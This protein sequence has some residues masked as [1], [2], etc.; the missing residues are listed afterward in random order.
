[1]KVRLSIDPMRLKCPHIWLLLLWWTGV[2]LSS[3]GWL[4]ILDLPTSASQVLEWQAPTVSGSRVLRLRELVADHISQNAGAFCFSPEYAGCFFQFIK[5]NWIL[6]KSHQ[7][8]QLSISREL[9]QHAAHK[10]W[11]HLPSGYL[12]LN[13]LVLLK[14]AVA[15]LLDAPWF[16]KMQNWLFLR[17]RW[18]WGRCTAG[19]EE[20]SAGVS[21]AHGELRGKWDFAGKQ[22]PSNF[23]SDENICAFGSFSNWEGVK[24]LVSLSS[25]GSLLLRLSLGIPGWPRP[26]CVAQAGLRLNGSPLASASKCWDCRCKLPHPASIF[27][28]AL[29]CIQAFSV[30]HHHP[31]PPLCS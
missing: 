20:V 12:S 8:S 22:W 25:E 19:C 18:S 13:E 29:S 7:R 16:T 17:A 24:W 1:M 14:T 30:F 3:P 26:Y 2:S 21:F 15:A 11:T 10:F 4:Q 28:Y 9:V 5:K 6:L 27:T 23:T 31:H